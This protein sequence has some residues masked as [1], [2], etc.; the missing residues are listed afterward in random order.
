MT[1]TV[2]PPFRR[3]RVIQNFTENGKTVQYFKDDC[4]VNNIMKKYEATGV[5]WT[6]KDK[7]RYGDFTDV[8]DYQDAL[9]K[10]R[11]AENSFDA[12]PSQVRKYFNNDPSEFVEFC[13]KQE[14]LD[15]MR[16]LGLAPEARE[17]PKEIMENEGTEAAE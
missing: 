5:L 2:A 9:H 14:N 16:R 4:D 17:I 3:R 8:P 15:E 7:P 13:S 11:E 12:L 6:T 1:E 10:V